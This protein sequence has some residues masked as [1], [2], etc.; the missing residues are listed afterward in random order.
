M[1]LTEAV[2]NLEIRHAY[3]VRLVDRNV[4]KSGYA[5]VEAMAIELAITALLE[6]RLGM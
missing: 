4:A 5:Y 6:K 3:L 1:S 2:R